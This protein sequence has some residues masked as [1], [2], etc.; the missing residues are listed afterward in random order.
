[1]AAE[2][3]KMLELLRLDICELL[4]VD[5]MISFSTK[6]VFFASITRR[7]NGGLVL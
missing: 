1:M 5:P 4:E 6:Y 3:N 7:R 2:V